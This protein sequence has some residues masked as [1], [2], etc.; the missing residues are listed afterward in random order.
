VVMLEEFGAPNDVTVAARRIL[1]AMARPYVASGQE[2]VVTASM[3]ISAFPEDGEDAQALLKAA[4]I[5]MYRAKESGKNNFQYYSPQMN[6]HTFERLSLESNLRRALE[7]G[8]FLLHYQPQFDVGSGALVGAEALIRWRHPDLG[9][10]PPA[11]FIPLAEETGLIVPIGSWVLRTA[12]AQGRAWQRQGLP[13]VRVAVNIS[14]RQF[15]HE[16]LLAQVM[17]VLEDTGL[18]PDLVELEI[19]ESMLMHDL[20]QTVRMLN[21]LKAL[22]I[23]LAIDDFGTGHSSLAYLKRFPVGTL[24]IDRSFVQDLPGDADGVAITLA[25]VSLA[26]NLRLKVTA[27]G[28]ETEEQLA[29][30]RHHGCDEIQ[31]YLTGRPV[32][33]EDFARLLATSREQPA[34]R[35]QRLT[36]G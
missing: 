36:A 29:F 5:A 34:P 24:K 21:E 17:S 31:G 35:P 26:H 18:D 11:Q 19:T 9:L 10:V 27:E 6:V 33:A 3:G 14:S 28:V 2:F 16:G 1:E 22:G 7:R 32:A 12:C 8:E 15:T 25:I 23:H 20:E 4:D 13:P 30:L